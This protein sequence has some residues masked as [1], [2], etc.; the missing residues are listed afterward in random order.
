MAAMKATKAMKTMMPIKAGRALR[1]VTKPMKAM[2][3]M[4]KVSLGWNKRRVYVFKTGQTPGRLREDDLVKNKRGRIVSQKGS[5]ANKTNLW[6]AACI[7]ARQE[8]KVKGFKLVKKGTPLYD[9]AR[10]FYAKLQQDRER[11]NRWYGG[12]TRVSRRWRRGCLPQ[13]YV[14]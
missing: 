4:R 9:K 7:V 8:L 5:A 12:R 14:P 13:G 10:K 3:P 11:V 1:K 6:I 2:K